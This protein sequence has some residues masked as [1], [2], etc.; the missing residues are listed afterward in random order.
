MVTAGI[1][2]TPDTDHASRG[3]ILRASALLCLAALGIA[4]GQ[5]LAEDVPTPV[6]RPRQPSSAVQA[7][8]GRIFLLRG[9]VNVFSLGMDTLARQL[10]ARGYPARVTNFTHWREFAVLL[11]SNYRTDKSITPV[12]IIGHSLGADAAID[13]GNFL[14]ENGVPVRLVIAFDGVHPGHHV[15]K[16]VAEV[17]NY[18]KPDEWGKSIAP[19]ASFSGRLVNIDLSDR[20]DIDHLNIDKSPVLHDEVIAKVAAV[21]REQP[22]K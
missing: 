9:L 13:M 17:V 19:S 21:Y 3:W 7:D 16:G 15:V 12:I 2:Q 14:A 6:P 1:R 22:R 10:K 4:L 5:A 18:Y 8:H 20:K 11:A